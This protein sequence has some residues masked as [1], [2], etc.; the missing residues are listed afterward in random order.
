MPVI[1]DV[2]PYRAPRIVIRPSVAVELQW[3][4]GGSD[5]A[6]YHPAVAAAYDNTPGLADRVRSFWGDAVAISCDSFVELLVLAHHGGVLFSSD[7][8]TL[9]DQLEAACATSPTD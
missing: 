1:S 7:S 9:L 6:D 5:R 4:L 8:R 2:P 3:A